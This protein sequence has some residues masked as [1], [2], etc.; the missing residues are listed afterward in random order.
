MQ[1]HLRK[2]DIVARVGGDEFAILQLGGGRKDI[3]EQFA[4]RVLKNISQ[5]HE[6]LGHK[7]NAGASIGI[8]LAP[9]HGQDPD[10]LFASADA[11]LYSAKLERL[12]AQRSP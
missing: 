12:P 1:R 8:A 9:E 5:P 6:V 4:T 10:L 7:L 3:A 2:T 11:A